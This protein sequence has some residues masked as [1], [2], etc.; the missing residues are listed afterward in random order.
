MGVSLSLEERT[1]DATHSILNAL[2]AGDMR[3]LSFT[4]STSLPHVPVFVVVVI[5]VVV[6]VA[7]WLSV[8]A[9]E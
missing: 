5:I 1:T 4:L 9:S 2:R 3:S 6:V 8:R 7:N